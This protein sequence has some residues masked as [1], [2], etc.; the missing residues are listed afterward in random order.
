MERAISSIQWSD[1]GVLP[2]ENFDLGSPAFQYIFLRNQGQ[3]LGTKM[4]PLFAYI[5]F[6]YILFAF[7]QSSLVKE[8]MADLLSPLKYYFLKQPGLP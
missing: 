1:I 6:I 5:C 2:G 7:T 3:I 4:G 8:N